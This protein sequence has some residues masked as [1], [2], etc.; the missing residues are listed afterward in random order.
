VT[1]APPRALADRCPGLLRPHR[2][3]DGLLVRLRVPGGQTTSAVLLR[4]SEISAE[5]G[6]GSV[7]L[8]SRGNLQLRGLDEGRLAEVVGD[9]AAVG[10]LPSVTHELV[11]NIAA[12]PLSGLEGLAPQIPVADQGGMTPAVKSQGS[13]PR[14]PDVRPMVEQLD[15]AVCAAPTLANLPGR[16]LF[17]LDDGRD[18]VSSLTFDLGYRATGPSDGVVLIGDRAHGIETTQADAVGLMIELAHTF[19]SLRQSLTP[20]PWRV[21]EVAGGIAPTRDTGLDGGAETA[22]PLGVVGSSASVAVP[23]ALLNRRQ[24]EAIDQVAQGG[25]VVV[26]PWRGVVIPGAAASIEL[27]AEAGLIVDEASA[28][29]QLTACIGAPGCAKSLIDTQSLATRLAAALPAAPPVPVHLSGCE[30]RCGA[31]AT[32]HRDLVAPTSLDDALARVL[33]GPAV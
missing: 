30:R 5:F 14:R 11:R 28:W 10:L 1:S 9:L 29:S 31:P 18:D 27:L 6:E 16:F 15:T 24:I 13:T 3:E 19:L 32:D 8:T 25:P 20:P 12:S 2:A 7:Q 4:L 17:V 21:G 22:V 33:T 23:L 26:T